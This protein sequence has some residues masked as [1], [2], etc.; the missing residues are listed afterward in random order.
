MIFF[1]EDKIPIE[2]IIKKIFIKKISKYKR[3]VNIMLTG[4]N[5]IKKFYKN[6]EKIKLKKKLN[7]FQTDERIAEQKFLISYQ[8]SKNTFFKKNYLNLI[9]LKTKKIS[10]YEYILP[11]KIDLVLLSLGSDG[12]I[13]SIFKYKKSKT[14]NFNKYICSHA[15]TFPFK[16]YTA[17]ME[18]INNSK[19][20]F[21]LVKGFSKGKILKRVLTNKK[22]MPV[23]FIKKPTFFIDHQA[24]QGFLS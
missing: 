21:V 15:S 7:I 10:D 18:Y 22:K 19:N 23:Q 6:L 9:N 17:S 20:I 24:I 14:K 8:I 4:G 13:A 2:N 16:R 12:H 11:N 1:I 3:D 5:S